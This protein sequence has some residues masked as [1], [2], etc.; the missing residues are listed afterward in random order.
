MTPLR[1]R[2]IEHMALHGLSENTQRAYIGSIYHLAKHYGRSPDTVTEEE[3]KVWLL[4]ESLE[5]K[6]SWSM[7]KIHASALRFFYHTVLGRDAFSIPV[8]SRR[9]PDRLPE[10][11]DQEEVRKLFDSAQTIKHRSILMLVYG[12]GLR[13]SEVAKL[14]V[15]DIDSRRMM[16]RVQQGKGRKD[17]YVPLTAAILK[18]LREYWRAYRPSSWLFEGNTARGYMLPSSIQHVYKEAKALAGITKGRGIHTLRHSY[19]THLLENGVDSVIV[20]ALLGHSH[21]TTT[22]RYLRVTERKLQS[23]QS[24]LDVLLS[25]PS[26]GTKG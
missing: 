6:K 23:T 12:T 15:Q 10:I 26:T 16:I 2:M 20:Q 7:I 19:A 5:R 4:K 22:M 21:I 17:R 14:R 18:V 13:V 3:V 25:E 1:Q 9:K 24:P 11:L 8:A